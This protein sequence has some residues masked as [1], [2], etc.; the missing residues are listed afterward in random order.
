MGMGGLPGRYARG[1]RAAQA[2]GMR[3]YMYMSDGPQVLMSQ[4]L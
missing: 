4:L 2:Q 1:P 3:V